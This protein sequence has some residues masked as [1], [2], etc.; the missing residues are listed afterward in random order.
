MRGG[1]SDAADSAEIMCWV[2]ES[3]RPFNIM[4]DRGFNCLMK[5][6][7]PEYK[8]PSPTTVGRDVHKVFTRV[9]QRVAHWLQARE[10]QRVDFE[11]ARLT[12]KQEY[13][14]ELNFATDV[15][16]LPNQK[17]MVAFTVH[18]EHQG[19]PMTMVLD[20]VEVAKLHSGLNLVTTFAD[21][22]HELKL[23]TKVSP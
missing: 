12:H 5:T 19:T 8:L 7:C 11:I 13:N 1:F 10:N 15:W 9:Q 23:E 16:T 20:V 21:M 17:V 14:G 18:F 4:K 2:T 22:I 3:M 6:G